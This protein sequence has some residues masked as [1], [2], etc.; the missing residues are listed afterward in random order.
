MMSRTILALTLV[1]FSLSA[2]A[3]TLAAPDRLALSE[4][5]ILAEKHPNPRTLVDV[6]GGHPVALVRRV[7]RWDHR[8]VERGRSAM[9]NLG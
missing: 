1:G 4:L 8:T 6:A 5:E 3:Q 7:P 9:E 2:D